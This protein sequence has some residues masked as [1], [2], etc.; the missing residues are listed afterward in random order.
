MPGPADIATGRV[1]DAAGTLVR[2]GSDVRGE[3]A[4]KLPPDRYDAVV[5]AVRELIE[6]RLVTV[7]CPPPGPDAVELVRVEAQGFVCVISRAAADPP[8]RETPEDAP[9]TPTLSPR[10]YEIVRMVSQG[11]TN[12][13]IASV[14]DISPWTVGTH[15]RRIFTKFH[16]NSRAAMVA[17][18]LGADD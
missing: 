17:H 14:L 15:L 9:H 1:R 3:T 11:L 8:V 6:G 5:R 2:R 16:V 12:S 13:A 10:E 7:T 4:A 18:F